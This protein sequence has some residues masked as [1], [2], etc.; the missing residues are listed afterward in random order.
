[1]DLGLHR[2]GMGDTLLFCSN[3]LSDVLP[4]QRVTEILLTAT[5]S[6][7]ACTH[8][9]EAAIRADAEDDVTALVVRLHADAQPPGAAPWQ[10]DG[11]G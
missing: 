9:L 7:Q 3:G 4:R 6:E 5:D 10:M 2:A 8:L 1:M 11:P